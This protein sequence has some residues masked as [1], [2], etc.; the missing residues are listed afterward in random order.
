[1]A[2]SLEELKKTMGLESPIFDAPPVVETAIGFRF[3]PIEGF[4]ALH[5]G[6][7]ADAYKVHYPSFQLKPPLGT[8]LQ[9][10]FSPDMPNFD[11][12]VRCWCISADD[13]QLVQ[14]QRDLFTR[15][16]RATATHPAYQHYK[17]IRPLFVRDWE[18]MCRFLDNRGLKRPVIWQCEVSYINHLFRGTEWKSFDDLAKLF[19]I[20]HGL[21]PGG[22][23]QAM[24]TASFS[25]CYKLGDENSRIQFALQ[26]GVR[27]DGKEVVQL[28]VTAVGKPNEQETQTLYDWL[29]FGHLAVTNGF[30]QFTSPEA[31]RIW[32]KK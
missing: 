31:H 13:T 8:T 14:V 22:L 3:A 1:M 28:T 21:E 5:L 19:P 32:R 20:W 12:P 2:V 4:N 26:P 24:E 11:L 7:L 29:D 6:Q 10:S 25:V 16:W 27:Q 9:L 30:V 18:L 17:N 15:N 23:F